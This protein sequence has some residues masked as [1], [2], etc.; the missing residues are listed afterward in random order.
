MKAIQSCFDWTRE[1]LFPTRELFLEYMNLAWEN[2]VFPV[3]SI[4]CLYYGCK[5]MCV[6]Y[7]WILNGLNLSHTP[8]IPGR[9][10]TTGNGRHT[11]TKS[12]ENSSVQLQSSG[13]DINTQN[14]TDFYLSDKPC[15]KQ[16]LVIGGFLIEHLSLDTPTTTSLC[17]PS[18]T[19]NNI[20]SYLY[21]L[22]TANAK[23]SKIIIHLNST[24]VHLCPLDTTKGN[25]AS[26]CNLAKTLSKSVVLS[27][28]FPDQ[29]SDERFSSI[30]WFNCWLSR[31][32]PINNVGFIDNWSAFWENLDLISIDGYPTI[33]GTYLFDRNLTSVIEGQ[34]RNDD[35][36][37]RSRLNDIIIKKLDTKHG[38]I[39]Q[40]VVNFFRRRD[41]F[42]ES[43]Q[44]K[45][46]RRLIK[47]RPQKTPD[48]IIQFCSRQYTL[49]FFKQCRLNSTKMVQVHKHLTPKNAEIFKNAHYLKRQNKI[50]ATW[51][52]CY[53]VMI[54]P[55]H[56]KAVFVKHLKD[57]D[58]YR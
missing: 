9:P 10:D 13:Q 41:I 25:V 29:S 3:C 5:L 31:W 16:T 43:S 15:P 12:K 46:C 58:K 50:K 38:D 49:E 1:N 45:A 23:Y 19:A 14:K 48:I 52:S 17:I 27:G 6:T 57:L 26:L 4:I 21:Q 34:E 18:A 22:A 28:P 37:Q 8:N 11:E 32:C 30:Y 56:D 44:I 24:E 39:V 7:R 33:H 47:K 35:L 53:H 36:E 40:Q 42:M 54:K 51:L 2:A 55:N 20:R